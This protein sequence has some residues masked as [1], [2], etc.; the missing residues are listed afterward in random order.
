[1]L[2]LI[3][4][5]VLTL[6]APVVM[7]ADTIETLHPARTIEFDA[8]PDDLRVDSGWFTMSPDASHLAVVHQSGGV[9]IF[10][11]SGAIAQTLTFTGADDEPATVIDARFSLDGEQIGL[12]MTDDSGFFVIVHPLGAASGATD[13]E[14]VRVPYPQDAGMPVRLWFDADSAAYVWLEALPDIKTNEFLVLRLPVADWDE[15]SDDLVRLPSAPELDTESY[16]RIG[17]I[18]APLA[19]TSTYEGLVKLWDLQTGDIL[20]TIQLD[21]PPVFG[22]VNETTGQQLAWRDPESQTLQLLDF[23]TGE[24]KP[25]A[26]LD[27]AYIQAIMVTP[28]ADVVLAVHI[29]DDPVVVAWDVATQQRYDFGNYRTCS[30]VP[31]LVQLSLDGS[32]LVIGCDTGI[33]FWQVAQP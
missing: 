16:V 19:I 2:W 25:I 13:G 8:L 20:S 12:L 24:N 1:M 3:L 18:P 28:A 30:R 33:E 15:N 21:V 14:A 32:T 29:G 7:T 31:D 26:T 5:L 23:A 11:D 6:A 22:R 27:G 10:D 9:V 17:R 4:R